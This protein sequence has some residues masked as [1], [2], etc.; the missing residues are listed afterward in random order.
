MKKI[1]IFRTDRLGDFII[2]SRTIYELKNKFD[3]IRLIIVW[4]RSSVVR[5]IL[6]EQFEAIKNI[7]VNL[8]TTHFCKRLKS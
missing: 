3:D 8:I 5:V 4:A 1:I 7:E 2:N 6:K